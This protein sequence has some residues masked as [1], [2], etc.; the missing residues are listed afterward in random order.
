MSDTV[1]GERPQNH[2]H[3]RRRQRHRPGQRQALRRGGLVCRPVRHRRGRPE[4]RAG[5]HRPRQRL[6][7]SPGR[8]R[9]RGWDNALGAF[10]RE[11][12]GKLDALLNNAGVAR[13]GRWTAQ[14]GAD[15]DIQIDINIK[16]VIHGARAAWLR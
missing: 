11:T 16:G 4:G 3:H 9:P 15:C 13:F 1:S 8:A 10:T 6:D 2:L 7:P 5:R 12:G 14:R